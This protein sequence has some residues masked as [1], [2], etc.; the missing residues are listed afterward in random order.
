MRQC[1]E[2]LGNVRL[3]NRVMTY[4]GISNNEC[5]SCSCLIEYPCVSYSIF[6]PA[7]YNSDFD[8]QLIHV[9]FMWNCK[10]ITKQSSWYAGFYTKQLKATMH[11]IAMLVLVYE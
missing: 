2:H 7:L 10:M 4:A 5:T 9:L 1:V 3:L 11:D 6:Y 8:P